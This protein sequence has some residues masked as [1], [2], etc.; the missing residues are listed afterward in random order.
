[1]KILVTGGT[2]YIGSHTVVELMKKSHEVCIV[3]NLSNSY[4]HVLDAIEKITG[5]KPDFI[6]INLCD[7][8]EVQK[9]F[10]FHS[11]DAVIH[12]AAFKAVGES[13]EKPLKYYSNNL[14]SLLNIMESMIENQIY[15]FVFSSS[16]SI[17]GNP[18]KL[19]VVE[20]TPFGEAESPYARSKQMCERILLDITS[21][22]SLQA[23]TLRY[24]NPIGSHESILLG[25]WPID[26]PNNLVPVLT[27]AAAGKRA[28]LQ[29]YGNDY[30][31]PDGS[32]I[33]DYIHVVD[34][35]DAHVSAIEHLIS[36]RNTNSLEV[37]NLGSGIGYSVFEVIQCFEKINDKKIN[38]TITDRRP[39]DVEKIY[40]DSSKAKERLGWTAKTS[41][42]ESLLSAWKW[43]MYLST[44]KED[45]V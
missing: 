23:I 4:I 25:E 44:V 42:E 32:C 29:V 30:N 40:A 39:G 21:A 14:V 38:F 28:A 13:V 11:F 12:F 37:Y 41:L 33:R 18:D 35:A 3:D 16:C 8:Y 5:K 6:N 34:V 20:D 24:F 26:K 9:L 1:M 2:G 19:P 15:N 45:S 10:K 31:T 43:E 22:S 7:K 17:Y 36:K 27:Q